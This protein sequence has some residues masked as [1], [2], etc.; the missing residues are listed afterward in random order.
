MGIH[1][2]MTLIQEKAPKAIK[3]V[4]M[5][6]LTGKV[7][8]CDASMAIYQFLIATQGFSKSGNPGLFELKDV[9]GNLTGHLVGL[10]HRTIQF[11]EAGV[12]PI[13]VFDGKPPD[14]KAHELDKRKESKENAEEQ[15]EKA[16]ESGDWEKVKQMAGRSI[17]I[18][19]EMMS[20]AKKLVRLMGCPIVEAP[21]EAEA[22]CAMI[23]KHGLAF[24]TA[25]EDMDCLTFGT[26][27]MI[28][29]LNS[30]KE[31]LTQIELKVMLEQFEMTMD[32]FVDLCILCGCDYTKNIG[33]IG[34][35]KAF[36]FVKDH[37]TIEKVLESIAE[38]ALD[39]KKKVKYIVPSDFRYVE[40]RALF[41]APDVIEDKAEL[42][43]QIK[44]MKPDEDG[45]KEF[46]VGS[47]GFT[48]QKVDTGLKKLAGAQTKVNQS[49]LDCFFKS[50]GT[51]QSKMPAPVKKG[52]KDTRK[53]AGAKPGK[54]K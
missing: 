31:P 29:G 25:T 48:E 28:R 36:K 54:G 20:D 47:K 5:D 2:L 38:D 53:S 7:V 40:S 4:H 34:P 18:T 11:M 15:K 21:C 27:F 35:V 9:D 22:Q 1:K 16:I 50:A 26:N 8:A 52:A 10:Y 23:V 44:W 41:N 3:Q 33:G 39:E 6:M 12:K 13:W 30:K 14:L 17:K 46:L 42:E 45:L 49:R 51:S 43:K 37:S 32:E 19:P 24:A